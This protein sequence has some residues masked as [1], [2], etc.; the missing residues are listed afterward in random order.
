MRNR[1][2][3]NKTMSLKAVSKRTRWTRDDIELSLLGLPTFIWFVLFSYLPMFGLIIAFKKYRIVPGK[4]FVYSLLKSPWVGFE[5]F[6]FFIQN[7]DIKIF[8]RNTILYNIVFIIL[9]ILIPVTLAIMISM[10]YSKRKSKVYQTAMF[11]PHFMSWVVVSYFVF[12]FLSKDKGLFNSILVNFGKEP[13]QWYSEPKYWPFILVFMN[14]WKGMGYG[15]VVYLAAITGIDTSLYEAAVIDGASKW[16]QVKYITIPSLK[17]IAIMM[18]ILSVGKIFYS[19]F[20]LFYQITQQIPGSLYNVASTLDT[21]IFKAIQSSTPIG[22]T[23]AISFIQS[24]ACALTILLANWIVSKI[25]EE[26]AI[27]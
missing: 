6:K 1:S 7:N 9:G 27:I 10:L 22:M 13:I 20:G 12:A 21:Y 14:T 24:V 18:F 16:Q 23:S 3:E 15:M 2:E 19:D 11:F 25:D 4:S 17:Q 26:S 5:N 8:L